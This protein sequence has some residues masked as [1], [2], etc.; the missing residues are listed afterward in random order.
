MRR[1]PPSRPVA[2]PSALEPL[3]VA[4]AVSAVVLCWVDIGVAALVSAHR[5]RDVPLRDALA[6]VL[7]LV[8]HRGDVTAAVPPALAASLPRSAAAYLVLPGVL[9]IASAGR[10]GSRLRRARSGERDAP[11]AWGGPRAA[12]ALL[13]RG[14]ERGRLALGLC[15]RRML[16][17]E[18]QH[19]VLVVGPTQSGKTS[20]FVVPALLEWEGPVLATSVKSDL[21]RATLAARQRRGPVQV[22]DPAGVSGVPGACW[23][24]ISGV[25]D[26]ATARQG[27]AALCAVARTGGLEDGGFWYSLAEKLLA[28]LLFAAARSGVGVADLVRWV[29][30][31]EVAEVADAL[32]AAGVEEAVRA[33][34]ASIGREE[35]QRSSVYATLETVL[36]AYADPLVAASAARSD[37]DPRRL[38][39]GSRP[40]TCYLVAPAREQQRLEPVFVALVR[41]VLD[42]AF[43]A[44]AR[45]GTPLD[46]PLLVVLDEAANVAP[47]SDLDAIAATAASH[48]IQLVTVWQDLAQIEARYGPRA[49]TVM[50]NHRAKVLCSGVSD[51][52]T[53]ERVSALIGDAERWS[54]TSSVEAGGGWSRTRSAAPRRLAPGDALRRLPPGEAVLLYGH[55]PPLRLRLRLA[56]RDRRLIRLQRGEPSRRWRARRWRT[57]GAA[58]GSR[59]GL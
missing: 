14:P 10:I 18:S 55:L 24:P 15:G 34:V 21:V 42:Q 12:G 6:L 39:G 47:L 50:N 43:A 9:L 56:H 48:G 59:R 33:F 4:A 54:E 51:P 5:W 7:G 11:A 22:F 16:A 1:P 23:S 41:S 2:A 57:I 46:P 32:E 52:A 40:A 37:I 31:E 53:L 13:V 30:T 20:G 45:S 25:A 19:S 3:L 26:W 36:G 44:S 58:A 17:A 27:A 29:D 35:R 49:A 8:I 28:P 38:L